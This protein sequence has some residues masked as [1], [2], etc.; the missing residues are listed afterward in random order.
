MS[1]PI[2]EGSGDSIGSIRLGDGSEISEVRTGA[3]DV[4]FSAIPDSGGHLFETDQNNANVNS[5]TLGAKYDIATA[6]ATDTINSQDGKPQEVALNKDQ[7]VLYELGTGTNKLFQSNLSTPADL[8][9][10]SLNGSLDLAATANTSAAQ[11]LA[12]SGSGSKLF[13]T[14]NANKEFQQWT[15]STAFDVS[16]ASF[17]GAFNYSGQTNSIVDISFN[18]DGTLL[19]GLSNGN[20]IIIEFQLSTPFTVTSGVSVGQ[21]T[22]S[23]S[24]GGEQGMMFSA[25]GKKY[26]EC[27]RGSANINQGSL[28]TAFDI[29]TLS[30]DKTVN[31]V[32]AAPTG[33]YITNAPQY[34]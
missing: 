3:G 33:L 4:V 8:S 14:D 6:S 25:D 21:T 18:A 13:V 23:L 20:D 11:G 30:K 1:P 5:Q 10:A 24:S 27:D 17:D 9:T 31:S 7:T 19:F 2:R 32:S 16:T 12:F 15:L 34:L 29:S 28:S 22:S 26:F